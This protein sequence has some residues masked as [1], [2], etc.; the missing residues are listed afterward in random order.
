MTYFCSDLDNT[1]IYSY[2]HDIGNEK[3]LVETKE[4]KELSYMTK[5][6]YELLKQVSQKKELIPLTTRSLEQYSRIDFGN[7]VKIKYA[8]VAN[9]GILLENNKINED[10]FK[11]TN[12][13]VSY[14]EE[15]LEKGIEILKKDENICFE[16]RKVDG[17]S[18]FTKSNNVGETIKRLKDTLNPDIVYVDYNGAKV[19]IFPEKLDK[20]SSLKRFRNYV[21]E[22]T[23]FVAAG[24]SD[25]DVPML[26]AADYGFCPESLVLPEKES[27]V[28][29]ANHRF[30]DEMLRRVLEL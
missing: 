1:L 27:I 13:I 22:N 30:S 20:G 26:L 6:S 28:K 24:D 29:L 7:Q 12:K 3:V 16:I 17:L 23:S 14:A 10:W 15:E 11:E 5:V 25:F 9:G 4:G 2:R 8:L 18:V 19:Y 21:G